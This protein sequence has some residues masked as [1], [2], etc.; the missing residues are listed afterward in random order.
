MSAPPTWLLRVDGG[1]SA[2]FGLATTLFQF[3]IFSTAVNVADAGANG[4]GS[5]LIESALQTLSGYYLL[6][7]V[8]LLMLASAP[9]EVRRRLGAAVAVHHAYM[10]VKGAVEADATWVTGNP[11]WDVGIHAAFVAAYAATGHSYSPSPVAP[12]GS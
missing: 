12:R 9:S 8:V 5:S 3:K 7:G 2:S 6:T 1:V 10:A 11:W 4:D